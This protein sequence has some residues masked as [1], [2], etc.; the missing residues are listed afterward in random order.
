MS[1]D[2]SSFSV[3]IFVRIRQLLIRDFP[4]FLKSGARGLLNLWKKAF[5]QLNLEN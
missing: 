1:L 3:V 5:G 2:L 4:T